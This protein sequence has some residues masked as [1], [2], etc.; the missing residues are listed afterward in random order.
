MRL[1]ALAAVLVLGLCLAYTRYMYPS[2]GDVRS[3]AYDGPGT[4]L[5]VRDNADGGAIEN[6]ILVCR[7]NGD[8]VAFSADAEWVRRATA[9]LRP[10]QAVHISYELPASKTACGSRLG[11][12][13]LRGIEPLGGPVHAEL[14]L[15]SRPQ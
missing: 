14:A 12:P 2:D 11:P 15:N 1:M 4:F 13:T 6:W 9:S 5:S 7:I 8:R 3:V 10:E